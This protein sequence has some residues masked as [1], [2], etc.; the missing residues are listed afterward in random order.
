MGMKEQQAIIE[1]QKAEIENLKQATS[2][3][4]QRFE[5]IEAKLNAL[6]QAQTATVSAVK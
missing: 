3:S 1:N 5:A 4:I 6:L 2:S